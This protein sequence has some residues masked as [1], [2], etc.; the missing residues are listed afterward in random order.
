MNN[1][2]YKEYDLIK[3]IPTEDK[4]LIIENY[5]YGFRLKT[6]IAYFIETKK[7][8]Q[9]LGSKTL[10]PKTN[11]WNKPKYS[12]YTDIIILGRN[13]ENNH[14]SNMDFNIAY[15]DKEEYESFLNFLGDFKT[16]YIDKTL[17]FANAIYKTREYIKVSCHE[18]RFKHKV[19][20][21]IKTCLSCFE[22]K[23]YEEIT[24]EEEEK[25]QEKIKE[26]INKL[27]VVNALNEGL[28]IED[29][30]K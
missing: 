27:F 7:N 14:I 1:E 23:D 30:K 19:T 5:P 28:T 20:G 29:L 8:K 26:D 10:N 21:E 3:E 18:V 11:L 12:T 25:Q 2:I 4:P 13:K 17:K 16:D 24:N 9:R 22:L 15:S 6:K